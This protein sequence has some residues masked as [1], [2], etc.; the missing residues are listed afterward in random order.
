MVQADL[1]KQFQVQSNRFGADAK[2]GKNHPRLVFGLIRPRR[3]RALLRPPHLN[4][5]AIVRQT[6]HTYNYEHIVSAGP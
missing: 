1:K 5:N 2:P 4:A 6:A 3:I